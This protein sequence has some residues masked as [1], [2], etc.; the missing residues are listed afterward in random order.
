MQLYTCI[1]WTNVLVNLHHQN[2]GRKHM[3]NKYNMMDYN[4]A[5]Y[6]E[7]KSDTSLTLFKSIKLHCACNTSV[8]LHEVEF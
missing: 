6:Q 2:F 7:V 1:F 8:V 4:G 3:I 5:N